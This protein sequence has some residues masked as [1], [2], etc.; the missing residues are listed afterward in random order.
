MLV[1]PAVFWSLVMSIAPMKQPFKIRLEVG[2]GLPSELYPFQEPDAVAAIAT[3]ALRALTVENL[4]ADA[5]F[6][7]S[8][9][10]V[11]A[12]VRE[13]EADI[14]AEGEIPSTIQLERSGTVTLELPGPAGGI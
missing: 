9:N 11:T 12:T 3:A 7:G 13:L 5:E 6:T 14:G 8:K 4:Y 10:G 1:P 2:P